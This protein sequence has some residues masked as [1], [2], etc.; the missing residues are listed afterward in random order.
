[1]EYLSAIISAIGVVI[2]GVLGLWIKY[3]Q[4]TKDKMTDLK[5]E[6]WRNEEKQRIIR[7]SDNSS[8][9]YGELWNI[10]H[11]L[12]ADRV[13]IVQPHPLG[14]ESMLSIYFEV[15]R[16]GV[17]PMRPH[18][19]NLRIPEVAKFSSDLVSNLFCYIT[20]IDKQVCD[21]YAKSILSSYGTEAVIIKRLNDT[22]HDWVG[23]IFCEF[24][25]PMDVTEEEAHKIMHEGAM[26][27]QYLL[28]EFK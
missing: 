23:S 4:R 26:N 14:N 24:T 19:Q 6:K 17:E 7:R 18:I 1:M 13:Y 12:E 25:H 10:L 22:T 16:R 27:I 21:K 3:N 2:T 15:K 20:D 11:E 9:V 28:P 5:I 8:I